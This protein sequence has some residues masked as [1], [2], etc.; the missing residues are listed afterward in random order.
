[1]RSVA[2]RAATVPS[3]AVAA[4][5]AAM[6]RPTSA[7][8]PASTMPSRS[9]AFQTGCVRRVEVGH[10]EEAAS[11]VVPEDLRHRLR[12]DAGGGLDPGDLVG[13]A[14]DRRLPIGRDLELRQRA[15]HAK[16]RAVRL[17][18]ED[19]RGDAAGKRRQPH[20][21]RLADE[22]KAAQNRN[23]F[24]LSRHG[25]TAPEHALEIADRQRIP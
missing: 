22:P 8:K 16:I 5:I 10:G 20:R 1:M 15:L 25:G 2:K 21:I 23:Q 11:R 12:H 4:W 7:A 6:R 17:D 3:P 19:V 9:C 24:V 18:A 14:L 13:V